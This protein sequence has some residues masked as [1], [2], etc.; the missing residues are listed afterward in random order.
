MEKFKKVSKIGEERGRAL[1]GGHLYF[2]LD[3]ILVKRLSKHTLNTY[4][5]GMKIDPKSAFCMRFS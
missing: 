3:I 2:R 1:P 5:S 4:F